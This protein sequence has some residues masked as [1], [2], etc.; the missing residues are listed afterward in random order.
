MKGTKEA[1]LL[2]NN[3][4][5]TKFNK[6]MK[7]KLFL[8]L[9]A[10]SG[11]A[12]NAQN[13]NPYEIFGHKT[14]VFYETKAKDLFVI[15]NNDTSSETKAIAFNPE[16]G[17]ILFLDSNDA[18]LSKTKIQ[19]DQLL[20]WLSVD[21]LATEYPAISPYAFV[22]NNP[23]NAVDPD[24]RKILFV[25]GYYN[26]GDGT[27][28]QW[29]AKKV[30]G[31]VGGEGY[32]GTKFIRSA[33]A[34]LNDENK[35]FVDG[36]GAW[37]STGE[38]RFNAGYEYAKT[39]LKKITANMVEGESIKVVSHSMGAAY[40]EGMIKY[41]QEQKISVEKVIHLSPADPSAFSA[42]SVPT[43]QLNIEN[44]VVLFYKN[45][46]ENNR[47]EGV[48]IFGEVRNERGFIGDIF[49]SHADTKFRANT[50]DMVSDLQN[51]RMEQAGHTIS[52]PF[53]TFTG[54]S[55]IYNSSGNLNGTQ[56]NFLNLGGTQYNG[57]GATNQ[58][59]G[60]LR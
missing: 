7:A 27:M 5:Y 24:G 52:T 34:F 16:E 6:K 55:N 12:A 39:N 57:T 29:M 43:L 22:A 25:N 20:R 33:M 4:T 10:I 11:S 42:S 60:P 50:W 53:G 30:I 31:M 48:S 21:P 1:K 47:I 32:W 2:N 35:D 46:G 3:C 23:I 28:P 44:D 38:E 41:L 56:F 58:Y 14:N 45:F 36:R 19:P 54:R 18:I 17:Y 8:S 26:T 51:M 37:N 15:P 49:S 59:Q 13:D 40:A 9:L